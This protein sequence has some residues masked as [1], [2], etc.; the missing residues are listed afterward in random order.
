MPGDAYLRVRMKW[1]LTSRRRLKGAMVRAFMEK[2]AM[3][4]RI[5]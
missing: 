2:P 4:R 3:D 1:M 5:P